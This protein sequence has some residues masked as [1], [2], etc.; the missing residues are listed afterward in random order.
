MKKVLIINNEKYSDDP[1]WS[2]QV[3]KALMEIENVQ[4]TVKHYSEVS[5]HL[6]NEINPQSIILT[7]RVGHHWEPNEIEQYYVPKL[8]VLK[9][10]NIPIL[11]ICAGLQLIAIIHGGTIGRMFETEENILE[12]G[13]VEH[14]IIK[15]DVIFTGLNE[16][17]YCRQFH[18]DEVKEI[19][20]EF[21]LLASSEMCKVQVLKHK[22]KSIYGVQ[23]HPEWFNESYPDGKTIL[24]NFL[25]M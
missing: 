23:F 4:C 12:E 9:E 20:D 11:G 19:P 22:T 13:Y 14:F 1:G 18:R 24:T 6:I 25:K 15:E 17:F 16:K 21:E 10:V 5:R 3:E 7:G 2:P 8:N